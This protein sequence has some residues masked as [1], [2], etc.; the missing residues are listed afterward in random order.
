MRMIKVRRS[1]SA[2]ISLWVLLLTVPIF[3]GSLGLL[4]MQS[5][6]LVRDEAVDRAHGVLNA[7]MQ[8]ISRYL[9]TTETTANAYCWKVEDT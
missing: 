3:I 5:R 9:I 2:K 8:R 1:F 7:S 6:Q 4:Y